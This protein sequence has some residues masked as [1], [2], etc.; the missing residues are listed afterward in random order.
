MNRRSKVEVFVDILKVVAREGDIRRTRLMYKA[1]LAWNVLKD[2]LDLMETR[3]MIKS[4]EKSSGIFVSITQE[5]YNL[6]RR[7]S[8]VE[9][10]FT[11]FIRSSD[12]P[13]YATLP[14]AASN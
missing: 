10:A 6:L 12:R 11:P 8:D 9:S 13:V 3:G 14:M 7:F 4:E 5:G 1:N 2:S